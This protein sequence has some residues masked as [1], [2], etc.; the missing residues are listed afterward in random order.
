MPQALSAREQMNGPE[1]I[2]PP[3][4]MADTPPSRPATRWRTPVT[5][6]PAAPTAAP[7][8]QDEQSALQLKRPAARVQ[9]VAT[10][11]AMLEDLRGSIRRGYWKVAIR[12][13]LMMQARAFDVPATETCKCREFIARCPSTDLL[14]IA[15]AVEQWAS[16]VSGDSLPQ[17]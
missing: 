4:T 17:L 16:M 2:D 7:H 5:W 9:P 14:R 8:V 10:A 13:F 15:T 12:R 1:W 3:L 6:K 11:D